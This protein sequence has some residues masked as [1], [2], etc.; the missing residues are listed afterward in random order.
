MI[1]IDKYAYVNKLKASPME[2]FTFAFL[3]M[4]IC[5]LSKSITVSLI[6]IFVPALIVIFKAKIPA[7]FYIKI[8]L[9]PLSFLILS[10]MTI[11]VVG[12]RGEENIIVSHNFFR[13]NIGITY[14]SMETA[15]R[16]VFKSLGAVS[17]LYFLALTTPMIQLISVLRKLKCPVILLE[18]MGLIYKFT[19]V[20]LETANRIY[21]SQDARLGYC[22]VKRGYHSFAQ[23][24]SALFIRSLHR[25]QA[26]YTSLECRGYDGALNVL[27]PRYKN[28]IV[29]VFSIVIID[30]LLII[31]ALFYK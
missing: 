7:G 21:I 29:N 26:L 18:L 20:M 27:E 8:M 30:M 25:S 22:S 19:F 16:L 28:S 24:I 6:T 5:L 1:Y 11:V 2:K 23:L 9:L 12:V 13:Y 10:V 14:E 3:T 15:M 31:L 4:A 17:C